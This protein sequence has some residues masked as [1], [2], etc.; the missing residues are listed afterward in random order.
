MTTTPLPPLDWV[1]MLK[2][3]IGIVKSKPT[4]K[5][6][7]DGTP[8]SND[9][10]VWMADFA[11]VQVEQARADLEAELKVIDDMNAQLREQNTSLDAECARLE[12]ENADL[13]RKLAEASNTLCM[14][15]Q[16]IS[17]IAN[18]LEKTK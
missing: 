12:A 6:F 9:V 2:D 18:A 3:A 15:G 16:M 4:Y 13:K 14:G 1:A 7:I 8:L 5:R 17:A 10:P 11:V